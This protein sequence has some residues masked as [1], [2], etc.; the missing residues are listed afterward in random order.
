MLIHPPLNIVQYFNNWYKSG[1]LHYNLITG[2][3]ILLKN[4]M[5]QE[6]LATNKTPLFTG[7]NYAYWSVRIK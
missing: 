4:T 2:R 5:D 1:I 6:V 3:N 7:D